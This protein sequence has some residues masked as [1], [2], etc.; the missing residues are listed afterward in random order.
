MKKTEA[1]DIS[2]GLWRAPELFEDEAR[3][4]PMKTRA[5]FDLVRIKR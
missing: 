2:I 3:F 5:E 1:S 4:K